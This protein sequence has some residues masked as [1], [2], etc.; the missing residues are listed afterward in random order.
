[1]VIG[2]MIETRGEGLIVY[3]PKLIVIITKEEDPLRRGEI[4]QNMP[5]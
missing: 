1:M 3:K 5:T 2:R 4:C